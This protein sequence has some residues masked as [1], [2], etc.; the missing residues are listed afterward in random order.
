MS[1][2]KVIQTQLPKALKNEW[3][4]LTVIVLLVLLFLVTVVN[5][6]QARKTIVPVTLWPGD[7]G[8]VDVAFDSVGELEVFL[9]QAGIAWLPESNTKIP[10]LSILAFPV[11][12]D[13][14]SDI[15]RK[16]S[17]FFRSLL[18]IV[19]IEN[20][21]LG[22]Q[23]EH[24]LALMRLNVEQMTSEEQAWLQQ[25]AAWYKL[26]YEPT[27]TH[28]WRNLLSRVDNVPA[29]LV[30]AQAANES[31]WGTSRFARQGNNLFGL[32][33]YDESMGIVPAG[34]E[35]GQ[36][37]AVQVF[38]TI[39]D[40]VREYMRNLNS[41]RAYDDFRKARAEHRRLGEPL[42]A[43]K[44][45]AG[46]LPYSQRGQAYVDEIRSMIR[47]NRLALVD[48]VSFEVDRGMNKTF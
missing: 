24:I 38:A 46:L 5:K 35:K 21:N 27:V 43:E 34:R 31:A 15:A 22:L 19:M 36:K 10:P 6:E 33:T 29:P 39:R 18:P 28:F 40:S 8:V 45:A 20:Y 32:W 16:K 1:Q 17:L 2:D 25:I 9:D 41:H 14:V 44:L 12:I 30:L 37:H 3:L 48:D 4:L 13:S 42:H 7:E 26:D 23:R 11:D 47:G